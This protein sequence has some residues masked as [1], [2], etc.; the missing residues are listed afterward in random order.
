MKYERTS[1][2]AGVGLSNRWVTFAGCE[3][4]T[5][6][7]SFYHSSWYFLE[8]QNLNVEVKVYC[9]VRR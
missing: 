6:N 9:R 3:E 2:Q 8:I 1:A 4:C 7:A 5:R